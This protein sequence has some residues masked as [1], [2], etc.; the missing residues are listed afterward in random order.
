MI[1]YFDA[2]LPDTT[3]PELRLRVADHYGGRVEIPGRIDA[4][5]DRYDDGR[6]SVDFH[7]GT[8]L[9]LETV[10]VLR[11]TRDSVGIAFSAAGGH[12]QT[13]IAHVEIAIRGQVVASE[14]VTFVANPGSWESLVSI[15]YR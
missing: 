2:S 15:R 5:Y 8:P 9:N 6:S 1:I 3:T 14:A 13:I 7:P 11:N 12:G 10:G 4:F